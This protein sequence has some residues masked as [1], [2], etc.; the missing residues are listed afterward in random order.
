MS[1]S[2]PSHSAAS[3]A[4]ESN[5]P[6]VNEKGAEDETNYGKAA[7][8]VPQYCILCA[9]LRCV[10]QYSALMPADGLVFDTTYYSGHRYSS[11]SGE[12]VSI[13]TLSGER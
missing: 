2:P 8:V 11:K 12:V 1:S 5:K 7:C 10:A 6:V 9:I 4:I 13:L 3:V